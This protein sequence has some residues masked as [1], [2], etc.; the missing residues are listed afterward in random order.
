MCNSILTIPPT[1]YLKSEIKSTETEY[2]PIS[3]EFKIGSMHE[4]FN[5]YR[6]LKTKDKK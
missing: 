4:E 6:I 1:N 2:Y 5:S 3:K